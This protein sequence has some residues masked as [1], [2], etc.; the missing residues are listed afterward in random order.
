METVVSEPQVADDFV[1][2]DVREMEIRIRM[3]IGDPELCRRL[4]NAGKRYAVNFDRRK[5][6][7]EFEELLMEV[8][9]RGRL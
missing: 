3:L 7:A 8:I 6:V 2:E 5:I 9:D 4:G 1:V